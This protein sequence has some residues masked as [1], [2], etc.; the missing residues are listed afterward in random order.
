[1][2]SSSLDHPCK[3]VSFQGLQMLEQR[4][5]A[6]VQVHTSLAS[7]AC[8]ETLLQCKWPQPFCFTLPKCLSDCVFS[9]RF[10]DPWCSPAELCMLC[11]RLKP[12]YQQDTCISIPR[13]CRVHRFQVENCW[14]R[15]TSSSVPYRVLFI[16]LF[17]P[18]TAQLMGVLSQQWLYRCSTMS[19]KRSFYIWSSH[20]LINARYIVHRNTRKSRC[21]GFN[22]IIDIKRNFIALP[23]VS[24]SYSPL[25]PPPLFF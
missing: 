19:K 9:L 11:S 2:L 16:G 3:V 13:T 5:R 17:L 18:Q 1:M 25:L 23:N 4:V 21:V 8:V 12:A 10:E 22:H 15:S 6:H 20:L 24:L 7:V 14:P